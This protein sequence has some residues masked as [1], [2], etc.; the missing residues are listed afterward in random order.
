[1]K[2]TFLFIA[3]LLLLACSSDDDSLVETFSVNNESSYSLELSYKVRAGQLDASNTSNYDSVAVFF[4]DK[5]F[6]INAAPSEVVT[7]YRLTML[8]HASWSATGPPTPE[9]F[10]EY[11]IVE[12]VLDG[13]VVATAENVQFQYINHGA[14]TPPNNTKDSTYEYNAVITDD[15]LQFP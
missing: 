2:L 7:L 13:Q 4:E 10:F 3:S 9:D 14:A 11:L 12:A 15:F 1:M 8:Q 6:S 5:V